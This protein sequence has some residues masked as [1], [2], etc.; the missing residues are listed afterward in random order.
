MK[1]FFFFFYLTQT[2]RL[3]VYVLKIRVNLPAFMKLIEELK[4]RDLIKRSYVLYLITSISLNPR[5]L[6][7]TNSV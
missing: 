1:Q 3:D 6:N 5:Q 2:D 7:N 4:Y